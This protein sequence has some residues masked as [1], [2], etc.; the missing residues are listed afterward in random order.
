MAW[1]SLYYQRLSWVIQ[2]LISICSGYWLFPARAGIPC[3]YD[4][5]Y[6]FDERATSILDIILL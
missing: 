6:T 3:R 4:D 1:Q 5:Y 2:N